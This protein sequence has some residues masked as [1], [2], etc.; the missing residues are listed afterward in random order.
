MY[1]SFVKFIGNVYKEST[2]V[3]QAFKNNNITDFSFFVND[4]YHDVG[5]SLGYGYHDTDVFNKIGYPWYSNMSF[6]LLGFMNGHMKMEDLSRLFELQKQSIE[7]VLTGKKKLEDLFGGSDKWRM[8]L[9]DMCEDF[10]KVINE[11]L[12]KVE[13]ENMEL[14]FGDPNKARAT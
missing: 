12:R 5:Y 2:D 3:E 6:I 11:A 4:R 1:I 9:K 10:R 7:F 13:V 14:T 8:Y